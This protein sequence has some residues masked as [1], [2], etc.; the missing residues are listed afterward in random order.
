[1][2]TLFANTLILMVLIF[3]QS[4]ASY[5]QFQQVTEELE[6]PSKVFAANYH[7]AWLAVIQVVKRYDLATQNQE[8]G[9]IKSRWIDNTLEM[10]FVDSFSS[11]DSVKAA[12]F[13]LIINIVKGFRGSREVSKITI[14][15]RQLV[16]QDFLQGW[17]EVASDGILEKSILYRIERVIKID[18]KLK[19][20]QK[21]LNK[22]EEESSEL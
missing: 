18:K 1:M 5:K 14:L 7:E 12:K 9:I 8:A 17:K 6:I 19:S 2:K 13:K 10:N 11:S 3:L 15:K 20:I 4:C 16:E 22:E 21:K